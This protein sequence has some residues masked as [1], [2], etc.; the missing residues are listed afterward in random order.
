[1][2]AVPAVKAAALGKEEAPVMD[3]E[4]E[5]KVVDSQQDREEE[6]EAPRDPASEQAPTATVA[7]SLGCREEEDKEAAALERGSSAEADV[8]SAKPMVNR[9][10][11]AVKRGIKIKTGLPLGNR[12]EEVTDKVVDSSAAEG[13]DPCSREEEDVASAKMASAIRR[14]ADS[15]AIKE[16]AADSP[17]T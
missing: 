15:A 5:D 4:G 9:Q 13:T 8:A 16:A 10:A 14:V 6:E 2:K 7:D 17:A 1:M 11:Q 12:E 3:R